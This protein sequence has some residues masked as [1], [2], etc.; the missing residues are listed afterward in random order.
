VRKP[1]KPLP[2]DCCGQGCTPCVFEQ[3]LYRMEQYRQWKKEQQAADND[4]E[5]TNNGN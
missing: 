1:E 3:Y 2:S 5:T 4:K